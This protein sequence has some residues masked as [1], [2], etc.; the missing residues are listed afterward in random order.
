MFPSLSLTHGTSL[1]LFISVCL[2]HT[3]GMTPPPQNTAA[4][5]KPEPMK[6]NARDSSYQR[7]V[8]TREG[9]GKRCPTGG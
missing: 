8:G 4:H 5:S 6:M 2:T 3:Y 7:Q 9:H 1:S